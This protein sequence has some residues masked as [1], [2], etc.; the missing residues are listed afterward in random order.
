MTTP[1]KTLAVLAL[2][3]AGTFA[4]AGIALA[5]P[6]KVN[7]GGN[8]G[9]HTN[10]HKDHYDLGDDNSCN[11]KYRRDG[12]LNP[13]WHGDDDDDSCPDINKVFNDPNPAFG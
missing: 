10:S 13:K 4:G 3:L 8:R 9:G 2:A 12:S 11:Y 7:D 5:N 6:D 1:R